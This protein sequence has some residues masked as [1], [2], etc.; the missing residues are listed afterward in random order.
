VNGSAPGDPGATFPLSGEGLRGLPRTLTVLYDESCRLCRR[1]RDWLLT[2]PC[3]VPMELL[4]AGAPDVRAR[5]A[6]MEPWMGKEL[7]VVDDRG[8]AW[9]GPAAFILCL[10]ATARYRT[11]AFRLSTPR[12][13]PLAER[14]FVV[15]S[16]RRDRFTAWPLRD[17]A[18]C[19]WC[20]QVRIGQGV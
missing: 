6:P 8:R 13:A 17:E 11:W 7:V 15:V 5:F 20:D 3:L 16:K 12:L 1:C 18:D 19:T 4:P 10:W 2:Q 9:I 14:F